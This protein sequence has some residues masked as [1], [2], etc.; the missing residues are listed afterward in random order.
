MAV[1]VLPI[2][3]GPDNNTALNPAPVSSLPKHLP[4]IK[5]IFLK[6]KTMQSGCLD[7]SLHISHQICNC[8][9]IR[10]YMRKTKLASIV[11][12]KKKERKKL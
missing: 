6:L 2:P 7:I 11:N 8:S 10:K 4:V 12:T 3:G 9:S 5:N 1:V